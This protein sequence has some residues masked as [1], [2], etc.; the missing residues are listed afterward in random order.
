M[1]ICSRFILG[2][3]TTIWFV[4]ISIQSAVEKRGER[5]LTVMGGDERYPPF[6]KVSGSLAI[7]KQYQE[8]QDIG[9]EKRTMMMFSRLSALVIL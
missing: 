3:M 5:K 4:L 7:Y 2:V 1:G 6:S 9:V 8:K